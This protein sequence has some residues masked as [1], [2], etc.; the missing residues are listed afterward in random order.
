MASGGGEAAPHQLH[1]CGVACGAW[2]FSR[3]RRRQQ[4]PL[5]SPRRRR[6]A[7]PVQLNQADLA[8]SARQGGGARLL[9]SLLVEGHDAA[10]GMR[11]GALPA[12]SSWFGAAAEGR[13]RVHPAWCDH[14]GSRGSRSLRITCAPGRTAHTLLPQRPTS[15]CPDCSFNA[16]W[17]SSERGTPNLPRTVRV[18][19]SKSRH[20]RCTLSCAVWPAGACSSCS[21]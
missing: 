3:R 20:E 10:G 7:A 18:S 2:S 4:E 15:Q 16:A 17:L 21:I 6:P 11:L 19:A 8:G 12:A 5:V 13:H 9:L 14:A 1:T